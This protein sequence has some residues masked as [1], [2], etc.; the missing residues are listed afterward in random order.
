MKNILFVDD[1]VN[2]LNGLKRMLNTKKKVW[3]MVFVESGA[4]AL[5]ILQVNSFDIVVS[6]MRMPCMDGAKLL[7]TIRANYPRMGRIALSGYSDTQMIL[8]SIKATH[9]FIS[10]PTDFATLSSAI[11]RCLSIQSMVQDKDLCDFISGIS[12]L[13]CLPE[14]YKKLVCELSSK[15]ASIDSV[16]RIVELDIAMSVKLLQIVNSAYFGLAREVTSPTEAAAHLGLDIIKS[17]VLSIKVFEVFEDDVDVKKISKVFSRS[18]TV[19]KLAVAMAKEA[20]YGLNECN[21]LL[22]AGLLQDIGKLVICSYFPQ[23]LQAEYDAQANVDLTLLLEL[24]RGIYGVS[25]EQIAVYLLHL[26][27]IPLP[28]VECVAHHHNSA[29]LINFDALSLPDILYLSNLVESKKCG[30]NFPE[31]IDKSETFQEYIKQWQSVIT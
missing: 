28:V 15:E 17:L 31:D 3:H 13:P 1:E 8:E 18:Q 27:G 22:T 20:G 24:E 19:A 21:Q 4:K 9:L 10:K 11:E 6:D 30:N 7:T 25:H 5:E 2:I 29:S 12:T 16:G 23:A 14:I 26:W